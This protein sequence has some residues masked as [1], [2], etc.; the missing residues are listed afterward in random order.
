M[1]KSSNKKQKTGDY[2]CE[3]HGSNKS[4]STKDY[5]AC[6]AI[7]QSARKSCEEKYGTEKPASIPTDKCVAFKK[8][9]KAPSDQTMNVMLN[10]ALEKVAANY[11]TG[12]TLSKKENKIPTQEFNNLSIKE[13]GEV[14]RNPFDSDASSS[15]EE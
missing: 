7:L 13:E 4:H 1:D 9:W 6:K 3:Y 11:F 12:M 8:P 2:F 15:D 5:T 14:P 10:A